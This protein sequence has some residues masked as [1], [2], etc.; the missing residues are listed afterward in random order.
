[1]SEFRRPAPGQETARW[2]LEHIRQHPQTH[3]QGSWEVEGAPEC[4]TTRCV[5]GWAAHAHGLVHHHSDSSVR[6]EVTGGQWEQIEYVAARLLG[7]RMQSPDE[8][9]MSASDGDLLFFHTTNA[10]AVHALEY[11]A[12]GDPIDWEVVKAP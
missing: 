10:Q 1:M 4:G 3:D 2:V 6:G 8:D 9:L 7:L 5:A 12:K 11:L